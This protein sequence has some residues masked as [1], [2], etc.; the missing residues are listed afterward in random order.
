M[1]TDKC[2][3]CFVEVT[4]AYSAL[5]RI[6]DFLERPSRKVEVTAEPASS[7]EAPVELQQT[8]FL[9]NQ[10]NEEES[11]SFQ[12]SKFDF[13]VAKGEVVA[14]CGPVGSKLP[15]I[16]CTITVPSLTVRTI[17]QAESPLS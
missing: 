3:Y 12:V 6:A 13:S 7:N 1:F 4:Q 16:E 5:Q 9:A 11:S 17:S 10:Q 14:V 2:F 8:T 15:G